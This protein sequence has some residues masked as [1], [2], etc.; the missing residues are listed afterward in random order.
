MRNHGRGGITCTSYSFLNPEEN[1]HDPEQTPIKMLSNVTI[2]ILLGCKKNSTIICA[3]LSH[4]VTCEVNLLNQAQVHQP[5]HTIPLTLK[6]CISTS[7][8][9]RITTTSMIVR[10]EASKND[11]YH[12]LLYCV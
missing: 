9:M 3:I 8:R 11:F 5:A 6:Q 12:F 2:C 1:F 10:E 4:C 7:K